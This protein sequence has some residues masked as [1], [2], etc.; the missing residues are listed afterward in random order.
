MP[1]V[2]ADAA[3][4]AERRAPLKHVYPS[5]SCL[6]APLQS[7]CSRQL[8]VPAS[9]TNW[10]SSGRLSVCQH[11]LHNKL[12][13]SR[14]RASAAAVDGLG[15]GVGRSA[16]DDGAGNI[17]PAPLLSQTVPL[18]STTAAN[19][20]AECC[21]DGPLV[22]AASASALAAPISASAGSAAAR[23][24]A[25]ES[26]GEEELAGEQLEPGAWRSLDDIDAAVH[27]MFE[28]EME[29]LNENLNQVWWLPRFSAVC[30]K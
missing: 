23:S 4:V 13:N 17:L 29:S 7:F 22:M 2:P 24:A 27:E 6:M 19:V 14:W 30:S 5:F 16:T 12:L 20:S 9:N 26:C 21:L 3:V 8:G 10:P 11:A 25:D 18:A 15:S 1:V 28:H